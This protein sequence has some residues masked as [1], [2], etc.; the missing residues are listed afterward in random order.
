M[1]KN[2][3]TK[4]HGPNIAETTAN[5]KRFEDSTGIFAGVLTGLKELMNR[6]CGRA[7]RRPI[8]VHSR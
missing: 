1:P 7:S 2:A 4:L 3:T 5:N 8:L 6:R